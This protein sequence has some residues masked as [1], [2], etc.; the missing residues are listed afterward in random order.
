MKKGWLSIVVIVVLVG[1]V[2]YFNQ[3]STGQQRDSRPYEGFMAPDFTL[4]DEQGNSV[5][6][7]QYNG[8]PVFINFWA[9]WCPPCKE[10]MPIIQEFYQK[11]GDQ[12]EFIGVNLTFNDTKEEALAFMKQ[13]GFQMPNL[14]DYDG[15]VA[16]LYRA[17]SIPTS[18]FIDKNGVIKVRKKGAILTNSEMES[19]FE[20]ILED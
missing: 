9:S 2:L 18:I 11:Y 16:E 10:E 8:K 20:K 13:G 5:S 15:K 6:L 17:D 14:F 3:G 7:S 1:L 19:Y 4:E 12:I